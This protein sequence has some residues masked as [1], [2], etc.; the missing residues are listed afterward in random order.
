[1]KYI[2]TLIIFL[3]FPVFAY[4]AEG[5]LVHNGFITGNEFLEIPDHNREHYVMGLVD[6]FFLAPLIGGTEK[7]TSELGKCTEGMS[8]TQLVAILNKQLQNNPEDWHL[9]AHISMY[10]ALIKLCPSFA[11]E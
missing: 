1:M 10:K 5:V 2:L 6:G 8:S 3:M 4:S 9:S 11:P 7:R